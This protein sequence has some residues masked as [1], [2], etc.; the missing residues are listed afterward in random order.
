[1]YHK[2]SHLFL[3]DEL[4]AFSDNTSPPSFLTAT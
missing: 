4:V 1:M 2:D 3:D